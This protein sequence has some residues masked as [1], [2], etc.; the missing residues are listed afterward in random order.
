M[1]PHRLP[2]VVWPIVLLLG[3]CAT[4][5][6]EAG[7]ADVQKL[8]ADR[9]VMRIHWN[10]GTAEDQ[11]VADAVDAILSRPLSADE[12][13]QIALLNNRRLQ[14]TFADLMV[15]QADV[16]QA[17]LLANP[18]FEGEFKIHE[19]TG[20]LA[21]EGSVVQDFI[22]IFQIPLRKRIAEG[23][24][25]AAKLRVAGEVLD[26]A[27][28]TRVAYYRLQA[29]QQ[30]LELRQ[31]VLEA[32]EASHAVAQELRRAGNIAELALLQ[33]RTQY[34]QA[35]ID[36][37]DAEAAMLADREQL[38][39][40][41]GL[42][43]ER[44]Q[45]TLA[46]RLPDPPDEEVDLGAV[47]RRAIASSLELAAYRH[48]I[49]TAGRQVR[50]T[51]PFAWV[52]E[53]EAGVAAEHSQDEGWAIGP[54]L[55]LPIP[56]FDQG[57]GRIATAVAQLQQAR[58]RY[59]ATAVEIRADARAAAIRL[60]AAR[61]RVLYYR[62]VILPLRQAVLEQA[63]LQYNAMQIGVFEL[64]RARQQ[65]VNAASDYI[66]SLRQYWI[67]RANVQAI[68]AGQRIGSPDAGDTAGVGP[69]PIGAGDAG[70]H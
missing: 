8:V 16:V 17:G 11:A 4:V 62:N 37:A 20:D 19:G 32:V 45:W 54:A 15:A 13:V 22:D 44:S 7:F 34:E 67:A 29:D 31:T 14:A 57:Q 47:E 5:P 24:F 68:A 26:L 39:A 69:A 63:Q 35:K 9:G 58:E 36:V 56:L 2:M 18:V 3:G 49:D 6:R 65:Q 59:A 41:M 30:M 48:Q 33:E 21:F 1:S 53:G 12:A 23:Q 27:L 10:Q 52:P 42:W 46:E 55:S 70:G 40:L 60:R 51:R 28:R 66:D 38:A 64:L 25:E 61:E 50:L 43:G